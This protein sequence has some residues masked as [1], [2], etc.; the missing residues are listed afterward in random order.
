[1]GLGPHSLSGFLDTLFVLATTSTRPATNPGAVVL[2]APL[3]VWYVCAKRKTREIG[4]WLLFYYIQLYV[5]AGVAIVLSLASLDSYRPAAWSENPSAYPLL[6]LASL[7]VLGAVLGQVAVA[8]KLRKTRDG[9]LLFVLRNMLWA[10]IAASLVAGLVDSAV[11]PDAMEMDLFSAFVGAVWL[12]YFYRSE[13]V[14]KVF[15]TR[16][17]IAPQLVTVARA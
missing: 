13:R 8:H 2:F 5:G 11:F 10:Y 12:A 3:V 7:P 9:K 6:L 15:E 14:R 4:G 16:D 17:W 1:M